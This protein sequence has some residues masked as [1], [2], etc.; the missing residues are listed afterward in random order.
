MLRLARLIK[1]LNVAREYK[2]KL[3]LLKMMLQVIL[4]LHC[5]ACLWIYIIEFD[6]LWFHPVYSNS[7]RW[8][9]KFD[10]DSKFY[11]YNVSVYLALLLLLGTDVQPLSSLQAS[12]ANISLIGGI[13]V[14]ASV[15]GLIIEILIDINHMEIFAHQQV[16]QALRELKC[17][18]VPPNIRKNVLLSVKEECYVQYHSINSEI[19][20]N[21]I[22][23]NLTLDIC[24]AILEMISRKKVLLFKHKLSKMPKIHE[25]IRNL[26]NII[27][28]I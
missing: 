5:C 18:A 20:F 17:T 2:V 22:S 28:L 9:T 24:C 7:V 16:Q 15:I 13:F 25:E 14:R 19:F 8:Q 23:P 4:Y 3:K 11:Q 26:S 21:Q 1:T 12:V 27:H 10:S 6:E